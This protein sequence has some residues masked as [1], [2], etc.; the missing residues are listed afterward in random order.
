MRPPEVVEAERNFTRKNGI[1][2]VPYKAWLKYRHLAANCHLY[3]SS[4]NHSTKAKKMDTTGSRRDGDRHHSRPPK[5]AVSG[6]IEASP[7]PGALPRRIRIMNTRLREEIGK[8]SG[9]DAF[10]VDHIPPYR[11]LLQFEKEIRKLHDEKKKKLFSREVDVPDHR[12][13]KRS[14]Y[15]LPNSMAYE[16][17]KELF[18][19]EED[20]ELDETDTLLALVN[21]LRALV[22]LFNQDLQ[23]I[24]SARKKISAR[25]IQEL[26][27]GYLWHLFHPGQEIMSK[28]PKPQVYRV[29]QV[30]GGRSSLSPRNKGSSRTTISDLVIDCF[31][32]DYDGENF[33]PVSKVITIKPYDNLRS[34]ISLAVYPLR[35]DDKEGLE[36]MFI[37]RA[38]RFSYMAKARHQRYK[39]LSLKEG[40]HYDRLE[41]VC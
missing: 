36:R 37:S 5:Y 12:A 32:L 8:I 13:F 14:D 29:L 9:L 39:G 6:T 11:V 31:Y 2:Y 41:E 26:P 10:I 7:V 18:A 28:T 15:W 3:V 35:L 38:K 22:D 20:D 21:G 30:T 16:L 24:I 23:D 1:I 34:I 19:K 40:E 17:N 25:T 4:E 27:F 33:I